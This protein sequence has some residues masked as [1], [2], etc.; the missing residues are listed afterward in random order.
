MSRFPLSRSRSLVLVLGLV[1]LAGL[2]LILLRAKPLP[3]P[4]SPTYQTYAEAFQLGTAGLDADRR[5]IADRNLSTAIETIPEEPAAWANRG[6]LHLRNNEFKEAT[7]DLERAS[8][9]APDSPEI[10]ILLGLLAEKQGKFDQ[11]L[12]HLRKAVKE[13][14]QDLA[15]VYQLAE[16]VE[17]ANPEEGL[18]EREQLIDDILRAQPNNLIVLVARADVA[19]RR[20]DRDALQETLKR[21]ER[22]ATGWKEPLAQERFGEVKE[23]G[24]GRLPGEVP[25]ALGRLELSLA[26]EL[27][28]QRNRDA[29]KPDDNFA[30]KSLQQFL[31]LAPLRN[32]PAAPDL[33]MTL[34]ATEVPGSNGAQWDLVMP[35]WTRGEAI[36]AVL[37]ANA[38]EVR[39]IET[40]GPGHIFG[41]GLSFPSGPK[42]VP[43]SAHGV[44]ALDWN[45]DG[46]TDVLLAGAGGLRFLQHENLHA[47]IDVTSRTKLPDSILNGDYFGAWAVD[48]EMDGDLDIVLA[49]RVGP[50]LLLR[51]NRDGTF[52]VLRP[53]TGVEAVRAFVWADL[54]NDGAPDASFLDAAG[55]LHVFSNERTGIFRARAVPNDLGRLIALAAADLNDDGVLDLAVL[56]SD[57]AVLRISDSAQGKSFETAEILHWDEA[58][59]GA[60]PGSVRLL[61]ADLDNN[62]GLDLVVSGPRGSSVWLNVAPEKFTALPAAPPGQ[63][64]AAADF[65]GKGRVDLL[66]LDDKGKAVRL[67]NR[68]TRD[69]HWLSV[70]A[71]A[72]TGDVKPDDRINSFAIGSQV[73]V[74][75]GALIQT[76]LVASP[77]THFGLGE[78]RK[79]QVIRFVWTNGYPQNEFDD[80]SNRNES[81]DLEADKVVQVI[82]RLK[83]SCPFLFAHDGKGMQFV[84]DFMWSTPL[85]MYIGGQDKGGFLQTE[86]WV[87]IRGDQL[88]PRDGVY[89]LRVNAN[90]W[91]THFFDHMSL[92]VVDHPPDTE[93]FVDERFALM[94]MVPQVHVTA[95]PK[96]VAKAWDQTGADVTEL[97]RAIDGR[98]LDVGKGGRF[99]G[100]VAD[101][102][103]EV[104]LGDD[105]PRE[106]PLWLLA[107]GWIHPSDSSINVALSQGKHEPPRPLVLEVPD[108]KGGWKV[109]RPALGFPA[110][111]NKTMMIR[112]DGIEG[113]AVSRRFRLRTNM[114]IY[115]DALHY[116]IGLDAKLARQQRLAPD[117]AE[118]RFRGFLEMTCASASSPELPH[119]DKVVRR[120]QHWRD[121]EGYYT[122]FGDVREL[123]AKVDDRYAIL[124]AG[125]EIAMRFTAPAAPSPGWKRDFV[126]ICDGWVKDGDFN[127]AF[128]KT[129]LPLPSHDMTRYDQPPGRLEDDPVYKRFPDDWRTYHTRYVT[130]HLFERG[131]RSFRR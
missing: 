86:D 112:L 76:Q 91:E 122:R 28:Y 66:A 46:H 88:V 87:K 125:D 113:T 59:K 78:H 130:P 17:K 36:P 50:P 96:P 106:G 114:E 121:L 100:I 4:E 13:K 116:A 69:Y 8:R 21:L 95:P 71:L 80:P 2:G 129:V 93:V 89:D 85:G 102:W 42:A 38:R 7:R 31:R 35:F 32:A 44:L 30:G 60:E 34:T 24:T 115:W 16:L 25:T 107:H 58:P 117:T 128:S 57:G 120:G 90:L 49:P 52:S 6:L 22:L 81:V 118:L 41:S 51:N 131:L 40:F 123:L 82:Q 73:E 63:V 64:F 70:R 20:R 67:V 11:A 98:H 103:A 10:E 99:Q 97:V 105:A 26:K 104:D 9:L 43:P 14:S 55:K 110:G 127:T 84:T 5:G 92:I 48:Y 27:G 45:N 15:A 74:R 126:W 1:V 111:K 101:H 109:G 33:D 54:D 79:A 37:G 68:G 19:A 29:V 53:F 108:G 77:R 61:L 72:A 62:G 56:R 94:P 83:G 39:H 3:G 124:N 12:K 47:Y 65:D 119:Y 75:A 18:A 23:A